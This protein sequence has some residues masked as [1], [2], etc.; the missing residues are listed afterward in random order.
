MVVN[1]VVEDV[2]YES[3]F[4]T[5]AVGGQD[6]GYADPAVKMLNCLHGK[7][8]IVVDD[9]PGLLF[10]RIARSPF[11]CLARTNRGISHEHH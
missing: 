3:P 6:A 11:P 2:I 1:Q 4:S 10:F 7:R 5:Q 8:M 9:E